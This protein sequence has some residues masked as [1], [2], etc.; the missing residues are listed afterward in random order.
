M[1]KLAVYDLNHFV[2]NVV[3]A[4]QQHLFATN[5]Q[6]NK[7]FFP[8]QEVPE[9]ING[10]HVVYTVNTV[11]DELIWQSTRD[12]VMYKIFGRTIDET[13]DINTAIMS[14]L[15]KFDESAD[16]VNNYLVS[17]GR[18]DF[19]FMYFK[20]IGSNSPQPRPG[21]S[22]FY[23]RPIFIRAYYMDNLL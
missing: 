5:L 3:L 14:S 16:E 20:V 9:A 22:G 4:D 13:T 18:T 21:E 19:R 6:I 10:A 2:W 8:V 12:E 23:M 7:P 1:S 11:P 15:R 17:Q